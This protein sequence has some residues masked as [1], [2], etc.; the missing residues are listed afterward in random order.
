M[1]AKSRKALIKSLAVKGN[2]DALYSDAPTYVAQFTEAARRAEKA[3][4]L[5]SRDLAPLIEEAGREY[6]RAHD[7]EAV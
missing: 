5:L 3:G 4:V 6:R 1:D 7:G 2:F